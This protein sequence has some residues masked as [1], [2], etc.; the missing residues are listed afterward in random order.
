MSEKAKEWMAAET[1]VDFGAIA[2]AWGMNYLRVTRAD[3]FDGAGDDEKAVLLEII[4][5]AGQTKGFAQWK[6]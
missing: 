3:E 5:D 6:G 1:P 2:Q 4:P